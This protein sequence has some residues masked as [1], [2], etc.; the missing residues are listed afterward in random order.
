MQI[1]D[2]EKANIVLNLLNERYNASHKIREQSEK[3]T[4]WVLGFAISV[5]GFLLFKSPGLAL[6]QKIMLS[7]IAIIIVALTGWRQYA[8]YKGFIANR[9]VM[10]TLEETLGVYDVG[11]YIE[12]KTLYPDRYRQ[13]DRIPSRKGLTYH[14]YVTFA[15]IL[16]IFLLLIVLIWASPTNKQ[17]PKKSDSGKTIEFRSSG[18]NNQN[19]CNDSCCKPES[20]YRR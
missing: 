1:K 6:L 2:N 11:T 17:P 19:I 14:F 16:S 13:I 9:K 10:I 12:S 18:F 7:V 8:L 4:I 5:I 3:F 15:L 20:T